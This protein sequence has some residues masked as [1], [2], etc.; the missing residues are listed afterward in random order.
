[1]ICI[2]T[3]LIKKNDSIIIIFLSTKHIVI[4]YHA[5]L[6]PNDNMLSIRIHV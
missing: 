2:P 4:Y 5:G 1:M 6:N 3:G